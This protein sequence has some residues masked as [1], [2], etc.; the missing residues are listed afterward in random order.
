MTYFA[1]Y[2]PGAYR[3]SPTPATA[4]PKAQQF[5]VGTP[6]T[7]SDLTPMTDEEW[8]HVT[9]AIDA[10]RVDPERRPIPLAQE[11]LREGMDMWLPLVGV[12]VVLSMLE[13][14]AARRW[15]GGDE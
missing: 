1:T 13:L 3:I 5:V 7:E 2:A 10:E 14:S 12:A 6:R 15:A 9:K 11:A 8:G 4:N